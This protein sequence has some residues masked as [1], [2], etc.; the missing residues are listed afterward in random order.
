MGE[1]GEAGEENIEAAPP[2]DDPEVAEGDQAEGDPFDVGAIDSQ[3]DVGA[4]G[5][6]PTIEYAGP[7]LIIDTAPSATLLSFVIGSNNAAAALE[8]ALHVRGDELVDGPEGP[9]LAYP[10]CSYGYGCVPPKPWGVSWGSSRPEVVAFAVHT[11]L[12][13]SII[14]RML[15]GLDDEAFSL[16][17]KPALIDPLDEGALEPKSD[18]DRETELAA[19]KIQQAARARQARK[20]QNSDGPE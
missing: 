8:E 17:R 15:I 9:S 7:D 3:L 10:I 19:I 4:E 12:I 1:D 14:G 18:E 16:D 11:R 20:Q 2:P 13:F 5:V 6:D